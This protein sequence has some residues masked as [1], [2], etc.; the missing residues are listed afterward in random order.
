MRY[1]LPEYDRLKNYGNILDLRIL[2]SRIWLEYE[3][4]DTSVIQFEFLPGFLTDLASVPRAVRGL[5]DND[6]PRLFFGVL[7]HDYLFTTHALP[8]AVTNSLFYQT[9]KMFDYPEP[10]ATLAMASVASPVGHY[11]WRVNT[12][13]QE[14]TRQRAQM[15]LPRPVRIGR[16]MYGSKSLLT[17]S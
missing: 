10:L 14:V 6:D 1:Q 7:P 16:K 9:I 11:R 2:C 12:K 5:V 8:F 17:A 4:V 13:R 3:F 15:W